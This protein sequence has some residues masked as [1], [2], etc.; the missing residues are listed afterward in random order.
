[1]SV[2]VF[3]LTS[4]ADTCK[5][6][7]FGSL[8]KSGWRYECMSAIE[9]PGNDRTRACG[10]RRHAGCQINEMKFYSVTL[11]YIESFNLILLNLNET[12]NDLCNSRLLTQPHILYMSWFISLTKYSLHKFRLK[13][14]QFYIKGNEMTNIHYPYNLWL[15][16]ALRLKTLLG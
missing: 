7:Y 11:V 16:V 14:I 15:Q 3:L 4:L 9:L 5:R 8:I 12:L 10:P 6:R 2:F 13:Y 1:M